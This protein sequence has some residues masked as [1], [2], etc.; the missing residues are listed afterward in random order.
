MANGAVVGGV[1]GSVATMA[2]AQ[3]AIGAIIFVEP[4]DFLSILA[5]TEKPQ[6]LGIC[7]I[8]R[9]I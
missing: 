4:K 1:A 2:E 7:S 9:N 6:I 8:V 3:K 5:K